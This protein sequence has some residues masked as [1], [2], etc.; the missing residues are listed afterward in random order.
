MIASLKDQLIRDEELRLKPYTD[1]VGKI[2]IGVGRNLTDDGISFAEAQLLLSNDIAT[3]TADLQS[4]LPWTAALDPVR[5]GALLNMTFNLGIG[6]LLEF[7]DFL[8]KMQV[9]NYAAAAGAMLDS[10]WAR[11]VGARATRLSTQIQTGEWQ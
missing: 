3:A 8:A 9:G 10:L 11:Q 7:R 1:S 2:T 4:R 5:Q 6:G